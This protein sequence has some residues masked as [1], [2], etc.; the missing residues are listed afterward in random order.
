[1]DWADV[2]FF[3]AVAETRSLAGAARRLGVNHSTAFRRLNGIEKGLGVRLFNRASDG[4]ALTEAGEQ[5]LP[6]VQEAEQAL[7]AVERTV[8][9]RDYRLTG[10]LRVTTAANLATRYLAPCIAAFQR[11]HP[12]I[13][14]EIAVG[15]HDYDLGRREADLA[16]RATTEPPAHLTGRHVLAL[17]WMAMA[18]KRYLRQ[19]AR[20]EKMADLAQHRLIGSDEEFRRLPA[21][22]W[23]H[24]HYPPEQ[25]TC[26][27]GDLNTM[28]ALAVA[29]MGVAF[30]PADQADAELVEL[31]ALQPAVTTDLW[32]LTHP[33]LRRVARIRAF[34]DFL[35]ASLRDDARL[36]RFVK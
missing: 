17:P 26:T 21:F 35:A 7:L 11:E 13:R 4:Y 5:I 1:M 32:I 23:L 8:A 15:D 22:D 18:G 20:P 6:L 34:S 27:A 3:L 12:G 14:M 28:A 16:L 24:R 10:H 36:R 9:G 33:D 19:H 25:F 29:G 2:P 31:F 30:L